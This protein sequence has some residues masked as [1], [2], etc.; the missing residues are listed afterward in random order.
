MVEEWVAAGTGAP[1]AVVAA[2]AARARRVVVELWVSW[3]S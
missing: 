2:V 1:L 3:G